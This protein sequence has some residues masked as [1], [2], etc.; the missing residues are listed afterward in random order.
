MP[1]GERDDNGGDQRRPINCGARFV[2]CWLCRRWAHDQL[3]GKVA[4]RHGQHADDRRTEAQNIR[5]VAQKMHEDRDQIDKERL[6]AIIGGKVEGQR[7]PSKDGTRVNPIESFIIEKAR[8][9]AIQ[10]P[11]A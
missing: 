3:C 8:R 11:E 9:Q 4:D 6:A 1:K 10:M 2:C 5:C 7:L